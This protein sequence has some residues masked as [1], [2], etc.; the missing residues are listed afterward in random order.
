MVD[1]QIPVSYVVQ[2]SAVP[3]GAGLAPLQMGSLLL[4]TQSQ[5]IEALSDGYMIARNAS[6]V[7]NTFGTETQVAKMATACFSQN[8]NILAAGGYLIVAPYTYA[9]EGT[10]ASITTQAIIVD[11]FTSIT[12]GALDIIIDGTLTELR[13]L[14]FS[15]ITTTA[16]VAH[17][18]DDVLIG[19]TAT[20]DKDKIVITTNTIGTGGS[21]VITAIADQSEVT[22][23]YGAD[24]LDGA[25]VTPVAGVNPVGETY[26]EAINRVAKLLYFNG[27][28][29]DKVLTD[30]EIIAA[31]A[32]IQAMQDRMLFIPTASVSAL[33]NDS[34]FGKI[35]SNYF[36]RKVMYTM[37]GMADAQQF[38]IAYASRLM[39]V[40][41]SGS[42]TTLTMNLKDLAGLSADT[43]ISETILDKCKSF[44]VDV[45]PSIEG[46]A[47]VMSFK[48]G[49][50]YSDQVANQIWFKTTIQ[51][52]VFNVL[53]TTR[54][55]VPQT[56][57][58]IAKITN[59]IRL[60]CKQAVTNGMLAPGQW[61]SADTFGDLDD[62]YRNISEVGYYIYHQPVV[63]QLQSEREERKAPAFQIAGKEAG[64][65]HSAN[66]MIYLE[67]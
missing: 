1:Y 34:A 19:A 15:S 37:G 8:P 5:P 17:I 31:S 9:Q 4:L 42:N 25:N 65:V 6:S 23:L 45:F 20:V 44:G 55:K 14:D 54:T 43:N 56:E 29:T 36:T 64:A 33:N 11:N 2:A 7:A 62:F 3:S 32:T 51:R 59:A 30:D 53:A 38:A 22:D 26:T 47:K 41:Y 58:G 63:E 35:A 13:N 48:Q 21:I 27:V 16:E 18:L 40:N 50:Q 57:P 39:A 49:N 61:N 67:A 66:I 12:N 24:Y 10:S 28:V 60:I 52:D 46:L